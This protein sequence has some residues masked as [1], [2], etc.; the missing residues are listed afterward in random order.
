MIIATNKEPLLQMLS[1]RANTK[2]TNSSSTAHRRHD[3]IDAEIQQDL[4]STE[5]RQRELGSGRCTT[6]E[7]WLN[8]KFFEIFI[9]IEIG[10]FWLFFVGFK[11]EIT[12][13]IEGTSLKWTTKINLFDWFSLLANQN[14]G[15]L[16]SIPCS[17]LYLPV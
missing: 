2:S 15:F 3:Q 10:K 7:Y 9:S 4:V 12:I 16:S 5:H 11:L 13:M 1:F 14:T 17:R 8:W 6:S